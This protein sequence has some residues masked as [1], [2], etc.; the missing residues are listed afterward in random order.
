MADEAICIGPAQ[1][2][3]SYLNIDAI[4]EAIKLTKSEAVS[5]LL[6][7]IF[8]TIFFILKI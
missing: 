7:F 2:I 4:I 1:S 6:G 8:G 3:K 5:L